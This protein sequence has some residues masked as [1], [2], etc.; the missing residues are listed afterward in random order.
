M[1][2]EPGCVFDKVEENRRK[3][4]FILIWVQLAA[5][6]FLAPKTI[7]IKD[8]VKICIT[9]INI[10]W[11]IELCISGSNCHN[12]QT[13]IITKAESQVWTSE[14]GSQIGTF[15]KRLTLTPVAVQSLSHVQLL[16]T[17]WTAA[18]QA[19]LS[20]RISRRLFKLKS[21]KSVMP[22]N[23]FILYCP[24][25]L[26]PLIFASIRVFPNQSVLPFR[27]SK[28]WNFNF[29]ISPSNEYSGLISFRMD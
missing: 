21:I 13:W 26:L 12:R 1:P 18:C 17:P 4:T 3:V 5:T 2:Q 29:S 20:F 7:S 11:I 23:H 16:A 9:H 22:S 19:S 10:S 27:W 15:K 25:L 28:C 14:L 24:L 8:Y 6:L